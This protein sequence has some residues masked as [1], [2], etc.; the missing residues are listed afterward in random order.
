MNR[1]FLLSVI[2]VMGLFLFGS[3]AQATV[4]DYQ[5]MARENPALLKS[6]QDTIETR[7]SQYKT[8]FS[9][10][11]FTAAASVVKP[12]VY[13]WPTD[14]LNQMFA[15]AEIQGYLSIINNPK[16][17]KDKR[18]S[19]MY[20]LRSD[21]PAAA[22]PYEKLLDRL[23]REDQARNDR[24]YRQAEVAERKR[25]S[26]LKEFDVAIGMS[27][28]HARTSNWGEPLK[29]NTTIDARGKYEQWVYRNGRYLYLENDRVTAIQH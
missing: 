12:C 11:Q 28:Y 23:D 10:K 20:S 6:C 8:L 15:E 25:I 9:Q 2:A 27:S 17:D 3:S 7:K 13:I 14:E 5:R 4:R 1:T 24:E 22:K 29:I 19:T 26:N 21:Y 16:T 18:I